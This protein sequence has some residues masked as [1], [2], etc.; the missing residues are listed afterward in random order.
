M[1][2]RAHGI[3]AYKS[4]EI[5]KLWGPGGAYAQRLR[6]VRSYDL[7]RRHDFALDSMAFLKDIAG[8]KQSLDGL[9]SLQRGCV[10]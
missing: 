2:L 7:I 9:R 4:D 5:A 1:T 3:G 6:R 10:S 8:V